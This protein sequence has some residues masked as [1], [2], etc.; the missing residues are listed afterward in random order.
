MADVAL[1]VIQDDIWGSFKASATAP[2]RALVELGNRDAAAAMKI[3]AP[4]SAEFG[5]GRFWAQQA[6]NAA[7]ML[8][9]F[10]ASHKAVGKAAMLGG[11]EIATL[12]GAVST[13]L[14][15]ATFTGGIFGGILTPTDLPSN[16]TSAD[17]VSSRLSA[18][19]R[20]ATSFMI[21]DGAGM[22]VGR[23]IR[24]NLLMDKIAASTL[25][26]TIGGI[27]EA[28]L[29]ALKQ[30]RWASEKELARSATT[31][32]LLG[33]SMTAINALPGFKESKVEVAN[34][35]N[36]IQARQTSFRDGLSTP[37]A[38]QPSRFEKGEFRDSRPIST[39]ERARPLFVQEAK[40]GSILEAKLG[41]VL[42]TKPLDLGVK[43]ESAET[44]PGVAAIAKPASLVPS[45]PV[46]MEG[47][48][49][50]KGAEPSTGTFA[51]NHSYTTRKFYPAR[52]LAQRI[53]NDAEVGISRPA[54]GPFAIDVSRDGK[55][56]T[57]SLPQGATPE[58]MA[59]TICTASFADLI[60]HDAAAYNAASRIRKPGIGF[61][62]TEV[63]TT[64]SWAETNQKAVEGSA[65]Y[66]DG[67]PGNAY[68]KFLR[69]RY[70]NFTAEDRKMLPGLFEQAANPSVV[71]A[72]GDAGVPITTKATPAQEPAVMTLKPDV[73]A[74]R[75]NLAG[76]TSEPVI[77]NPASRKSAIEAAVR[78]AVKD[79]ASEPANHVRG[80]EANFDR[81]IPIDGATLAATRN[82]TI[83]KMKPDARQGAVEAVLRAASNDPTFQ[84]SA[85]PILNS[86]KIGEIAAGY[87]PEFVEAAVA[88][89]KAAGGHDMLPA[90]IETTAQ[91][92][93]EIRLRPEDVY[94]SLAMSA[95][96]HAQS[97]LIIGSRYNMDPIREVINALDGAKTLEQVKSALDAHYAG[98]PGK[99]ES[100]YTAAIEKA[101]KVARSL[102]TSV[103]AI[104]KSGDPVLHNLLKFLERPRSADQGPRP[105]RI[106][107]GTV[108]P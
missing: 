6:G 27:A 92:A 82:P 33:G 23:G 26:G 11:A 104:T 66:V 44:Q 47:M 84:P 16:Y 37:S 59:A 71:P 90:T 61:N 86:V 55:V 98:E 81:V 74:F 75:T 10:V 101:A 35:P 58:Q 18:A 83:A 88:I 72:L 43:P 100:S 106:A 94:R 4:P 20:T 30:G 5:T 36:S 52:E 46:I 73:E 65:A 99:A 25:G 102:R 7:G 60:A 9:W 64:A 42:E 13:K 63:E 91:L 93:K 29:H 95:G 69:D 34:Q 49:V 3:E 85:D 62:P 38:F 89:N 50:P 57:I 48:T 107:E 87:S 53:A 105:L 108:K 40:P 51:D 45:N 21:M 15:K 56:K 96:H 41:S 80:R 97:K 103:D 19:A 76:N 31:Y 8:P 28:E 77:S 54:E 67:K 39:P 14:A 17:V 32:A 70:G 78:A 22:A 24:S 2:V 79:S 1:S 12:E 68:T